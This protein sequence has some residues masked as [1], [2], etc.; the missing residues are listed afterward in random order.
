MNVPSKW[1]SGILWR[2]AADNFKMFEYF[3]EENDPISEAR[4]QGCFFFFLFF[5]MWKWSIYFHFIARRNTSETPINVHEDQ[6]WHK[7][8]NMKNIIL[9]LELILMQNWN[10]LKFEFKLHT[11]TSI[12][13]KYIYIKRSTNLWKVQK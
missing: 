8:E 7:Q 9:I 4:W 13:W 1:H 12:Y 6:K 3:C 5:P 11:W 10:R 2:G